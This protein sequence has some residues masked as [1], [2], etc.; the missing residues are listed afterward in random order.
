MAGANCVHCNEKNETRNNVTKISDGL[1]DYSA[2]DK[3][4]DTHRAEAQA[5]EGIYSSVAEFE[6]YA[7]RIDQ[8]SGILRFGQTVDMD[9]GEIGLTLREAHFCRVRHCPVC[10]WRRSLMWLARFYQSLPEIQQAHPKARW[11]FLTVTVRNPPVGE[12]RTTLQ[13][14]NQAWQRFIKRKEFA[15]VLGWIR[16]TEVTR[17]KDGSAH[18]HFHCLLMVPPTMFTKHYVKQARWTELWRDC[19]RLDYQP[20]VDV[21]TVKSKA[22]KGEGMDAADPMD[23]LRKA[24]AET[25]KYSVKPSDMVNDPDWFLEMTKQVH[26]LRFVATGGVLKDVLRVDDE[27]DQDLIVADEVAEQPDDGSRLAFN[28]RRDD[29]R[30]RRFAKGDKAPEGAKS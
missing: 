28:W 2:R 14:M 7:Q 21:R 20:M 6:R 12:L 1:T 9:T 23:G 29:K 18:P 16:T 15:P 10:Q 27:S 17:G 24:A 25:L 22:P 4:W 19:A 5:V 13:A 26:R 3:P 30:Y 8:C 11:I